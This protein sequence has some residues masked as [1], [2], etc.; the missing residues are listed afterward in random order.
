MICDVSFVI[1]HEILSYMT[2]LR[3]R[4]RLFYILNQINDIYLTSRK[5]EEKEKQTHKGKEKEKS[6]FVVSGIYILNQGECFSD[7]YRKYCTIL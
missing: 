3:T 7:I 6:F 4:I 2:E 1:N 5:A